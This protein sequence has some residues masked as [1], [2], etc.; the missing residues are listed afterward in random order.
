MEER[1]TDVVE[2]RLSRGVIRR[3]VAP[4]E[5]VKP[6]KPVEEKKIAKAE[7]KKEKVVEETVVHHKR[8]KGTLVLD[9]VQKA[10]AEKIVSQNLKKKTKGE[11]KKIEEKQ[12]GQTEESS[13]QST[14]EE[15]K[16]A[17]FESVSET[18]KAEKKEEA[19]QKEKI[20]FRDRIQGTI[21]LKKIQP[22][23]TV[24]TPT[25][26]PARL[27]AT[28]VVEDD[29]ASKVVKPGRG[30]KTGKDIS[31][32]L[33]FEGL[34]KGMNL[35]H[36]S[37]LGTLDRI[38]KPTTVQ[39]ASAR[40]K[41][42][43]AKKGLKKTTL[44]VKK[45]SKRY[46]EI[47]RAITVANLAQELGIK[48][49]QIIKQLMALG[50][51]A[52][53]NQEIDKDTATLIASEHGY[54]VR[55][56][57]FKEDQVL[58]GQQ[59][60]NVEGESRPPVVTI[61][62][63]VDHGKT[64]LLDAIR[65]TQVAAGEAGGI[66][67]HIGAYTVELPQ[68]KITFI[69]T[70]GHEAFTNM[71]LRGA[72]ATDIVVLVVAADDGMMPQTEESIDHAKAANVPILV[73]VNKIDKPEADPERV[74]RQLSEK[75]I[76]SEAWGGENIFCQVSALTKKG[77]P[78][79]L[80]SILLQ[81]EVLEL[82]APTETRAQGVVLESKLDRAR[83]PLCTLLVQSGTLKLGD[84]I[85]AGTFT[86]KV[87]AMADWTGKAISAATPST[88]VEVLGLEDV[89][90]AGDSFN[91]VADEK[92]ARS[93]AENRRLEKQRQAQAVRGPVSLEDMFSQIKAGQ[94]SELNIILKTDVQGSLEAVRN[95]VLQIGNDEVRPKVVHAG[96]GGI[97]ESDVT[98]ALAVNAVIIG[99]NVRPETK[100][101]HTA[102][103][104]HVDIKLYKIIY[105]LVNEVKLA[106]QGMLK[107]ERR[108]DYLGRAEVRQAFE[109]SK[110]GMIAGCMVV[111]GVITRTASL[112]LLRD[113]VVLYEG[114]VIS[115]K[116]F[117]DDA[118]E[119]KQGF[120][121]GVGLEGYTNI[122][123]GDVIEAFTVTEVPK[124]L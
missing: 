80:E 89:P 29:A 101:I 48:A 40:K 50:T 52:T 1:K 67:Q 119:V 6:P 33:N 17:S 70:P 79:L 25:A 104:N 2:K 34:G 99:F 64:S 68:G 86:G 19:A 96:V 61:M 81:S 35:T 30:K 43:M 26:G 74:V 59:A 69:D 46:V 115:L 120:E 44:T 20:S 45:A 22:Q 42:I 49:N 28:V 114:K 5:E 39:T 100:A 21:D 71:R 117:K 76:V 93:V 38:F 112:R 102:K 7:I 83:G 107:P 98:L 87:R 63:H 106:L 118:R 66:T 111:D 123:A 13:I 60:G 103:E 47:E 122:K 56:V 32:E 53:I 78:Q 94:M 85:V 72:R 92:D 10:Q 9:E 65:S 91:A 18:K 88:A 109:V 105:D 14:V 54:E 62:G 55:D 116:R 95:A 121:C 77:V 73:A 24:T 84:D 58:Q 108:E 27:G 12:S 41:K 31:G 23:K 82:K 90:E 110:L 113:N 4:A 8:S 36:L 51:M 124:T 11:E 75:G 37:R 97:N 15:A 3:R 57:A 16:E